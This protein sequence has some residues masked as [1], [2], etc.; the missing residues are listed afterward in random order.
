MLADGSVRCWGSNAERQIGD[1]RE[2]H[3]LNCA[4]TGETELQDC[5]FPSDVTMLDDATA[6][7]GRGGFESCVVR[8]SDDNVWSRVAIRVAVLRARSG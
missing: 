1:G 4:N 2:R 6:L 3:G 7:T 8:S 5:A